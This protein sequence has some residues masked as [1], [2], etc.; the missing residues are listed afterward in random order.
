MTILTALASHD[1]VWLGY[2]DGH[3]IGDTPLPGVG[4]P[5]LNLGHWLLGVS[6]SSSAFSILDHHRGDF[7]SE[8]NGVEEVVFRIRTTLLDYGMGRKEDDEVEIRFG[9]WCIL[10]HPNGQIW[11][12]DD[13]LAFSR[14][15]EDT[16]WARGSGSDY[17]LGAEHA[18]K[19]LNSPPEIRIRHAVEAAIA[20]DLFCCGSANVRLLEKRANSDKPA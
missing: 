6:G 13:A 1:G 12:V 19:A 3:T 2:N 9:I 8:T 10:V 7:D 14:I 5:W 20:L 11:D 17:A 16:L 4:C 18:L 15:P